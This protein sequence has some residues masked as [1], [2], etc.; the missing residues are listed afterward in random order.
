QVSPKDFDEA[1]DKIILGV[2][3][4]TMLDPKERKLVAFHEAGHAMVAHLLPNADPL[5]K[6]TIIPHGHA[7]GVTQMLPQDEKYSF[8]RAYLLD[9]MAVQL[10]GRAAE[11]LVFGE[12][13]TGAE[14]DLLEMTKL[15]R[16]M[17][18]RWGMGEN[19]GPQAFDLDADAGF[20]GGELPSLEKTY[21]EETASKID[22]EVRRLTSEAYERAKWI[23]TEHRDK[24]DRLA[25]TLLAEES[26]DAHQIESLVGAKVRAS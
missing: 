11:E 21:S 5:R 9:K 25:E 10:G 8:P 15:A 23:L 22:Q 7:L 18:L 3:R 20:L 24:L 12:V 13:T 26:L 6:V 19:L 17:V 2:R 14:N 1:K 4:N 16:R